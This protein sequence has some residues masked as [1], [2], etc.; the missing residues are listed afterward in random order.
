MANPFAESKT[1]H[2]IGHVTNTIPLKVLPTPRG[3]AIVSTTGRKTGKTRTRA[4]RAVQDGGQ[5]YAVA[6]LGKKTAW[7]ANVRAN[8]KVKIK[9]GT[10]TV[11]ATAREVTDPEERARAAS[12][13]HPIVGWYDYFDYVNFV[14]AIPTKAKVLATHD[15]LFDEGT[16]V[17]FD[18]DSEA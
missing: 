16:V 17:A 12:A 3:I 1:F 7:L 5:V 9:L 18:L 4:I 8:P 10:K 6:L 13:Y 11:S 2:K 15:Q 14:W